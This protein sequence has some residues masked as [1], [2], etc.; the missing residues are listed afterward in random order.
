M[1]AAR[2][3]TTSGVVSVF[4]G[5]VTGH[6]GTEWAIRT[7]TVLRLGSAGLTVR[8]RYVP[9]PSITAVAV[10]LAWRPSFRDGAFMF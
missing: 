4:L 8:I 6:V 5:S 2:A 1:S 7:K 3:A 9:S 10:F